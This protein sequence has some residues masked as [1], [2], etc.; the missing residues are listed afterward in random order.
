MKLVSKPM[1]MS[2]AIAVS[3]P[4]ILSSGTNVRTIT[5]TS[6]SLIS[7]FITFESATAGRVTNSTKRLH[8]IPYNS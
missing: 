4:A 7:M 5:L 6:I 2:T 8:Y 1:I 3:A